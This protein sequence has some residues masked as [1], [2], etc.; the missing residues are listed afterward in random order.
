MSIRGRFLLAPILG[1]MLTIIYY[2]ATSNVI[3][4]H[5]EIFSKLEKKQI[6]EIVNFSEMV[7]TLTQVHNDLSSLLRAQL[8][9]QDQETVH[10]LGREIVQSILATE[11][12]INRFLTENKHELA[13]NKIIYKTINDNFINYKIAALAALELTGTNPQLAKQE[14]LNA[15]IAMHNIIAASQ[16]LMRHSW[17]ELMDQ[18][19]TITDSRGDHNLISI[20]AIF[21]IALMIISALYF[22]KRMTQDIVKINSAL[23]K[24]SHGHEDVT[25]PA[26]HDPY[27][28]ELSEAVKK[29]Q[30]TLIEQHSQEAQLTKINGELIEHKANLEQI[31]QQRTEEVKRSYEKIKEAESNLVETQKLASLGA[32]VSGISH[33]IN[34]PIGI[35]MTAASH[36]IEQTERI[37]EQSNSEQLSAKEFTYYTEDALEVSQIIVSNIKRAAE[38]IQSFK[39]VAVDQTSEKQR[40]F[41]LRRYVGDILTS[42]GP[43]TKKTKHKIN[44]HCPKEILVN[45]IPGA[46]SQILT[47]LIINSFVHGFEELDQG[48]IDI[49]INQSDDNIELVYRD[50]GCGVSEDN[51]SNIFERFFTTKLDRGGSGLGTHI[52]Y[53]LAT[54]TL[55]GSITCSSTLGEGIEFKLIFPS[56]LEVESEN[57]NVEH[58]AS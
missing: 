10:V 28:N 16:A 25:V 55:K 43:Q 15:D 17:H 54:K 37:I 40:E 7:M 39:G 33:E 48:T 4:Q 41:E 51:R 22:S 57:K 52:I 8:E 31:I 47:N 11:I 2:I 42:L 35:S 29:F 9:A 3:Y 34:T 27:L 26:L 30:Q 32:L 24:L 53:T 20:I 38:L 56:Q 46:L 5:S 23:V 12:K 50:N 14:L 6:P 49:V 13:D 58:S 1:I 44:L 18:Y 45:T 19:Q 36:L 21:F